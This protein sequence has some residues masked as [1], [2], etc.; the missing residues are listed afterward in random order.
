[1]FR[2][3]REA[4]RGDVKAHEPPAA[5]RSPRVFFDGAYRLHDTDD[6]GRFTALAAEAFPEFASRITCFAADWAGS[7]FA[8]D[9]A[10][11]VGGER[12]I[13]LLEP[14][15]GKVLQIPAGLDSFHEG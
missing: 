6:V 9:E 11:V 7:Q 8:T 13:L 5:S 3:L 2:R 14:G 15:T 12:Q 1:M 4:L 10:R